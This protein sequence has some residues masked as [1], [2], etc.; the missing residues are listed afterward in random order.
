MLINVLFLSLREFLPLFYITGVCLLL[1]PQHGARQQLLGI[2]LPLGLLITGA[3]ITLLSALGKTSSGSGAEWLLFASALAQVIAY[4]TFLS[5]ITQGKSVSLQLIALITIISLSCMTRSIDLFR[6]ISAYSLQQQ[7]Q[8]LI[9]GLVIGAA[10]AASVAVLLYFLFAW[11]MAYIRLLPIWAGSVFLAGHL[12][13]ASNLLAQIG[14]L[15]SVPVWSTRAWLS[16]DAALAYL[17]HAVAGYDATP[18]SWQLII[19]GST[20]LAMLFFIVYGDDA[21][22]TSMEMER[23]DT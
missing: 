23:S 22:R 13:E 18:T 20:L 10:I 21:L 5:L 9:I 19:Y 15:E 14:F 7:Q 16:E 6:L 8:E 17:A 3:L 4:L 12:A 11:A 1:L 2:G